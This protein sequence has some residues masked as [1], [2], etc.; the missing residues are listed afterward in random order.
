MFCKRNWTQN[1]GRKCV[2]ANIASGH[3]LTDQRLTISQTIHHGALQASKTTRITFVVYCLFFP[4]NRPYGEW[5]NAV[6]RKKML[7]SAGSYAHFESNTTQFCCFPHIDECICEQDDNNIGEVTTGPCGPEVQ[8]HRTIVK[9]TEYYTTTS[10]LQCQTDACHPSFV[11]PF[12]R[13][14]MAANLIKEIKHLSIAISK[15]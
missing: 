9:Y 14:E 2:T 4:A 8:L 15:L 12:L 7:T 6:T 13:S 10:H 5:R 11:W 3:C 1:S